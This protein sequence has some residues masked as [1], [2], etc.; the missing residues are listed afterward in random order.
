MK[1]PGHICHEMLIGFLWAIIYQ[2]LVLSDSSSTFH[3]LS[4]ESSRLAVEGEQRGTDILNV[5]RIARRACVFFF[6]FTGTF[7]GCLH[8]G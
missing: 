4:D 5:T 3:D 8:F 6:M 7:I 2:D 1:S